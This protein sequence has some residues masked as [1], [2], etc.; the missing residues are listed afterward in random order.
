MHHFR[1]NPPSRAIK[2]RPA[3]TPAMRLL[4]EVEAHLDETG[5]SSSAFGRSVTGNTGLIQQLRAGGMVK[6]ATLARIRSALAG[7]VSHA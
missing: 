4:R 2:P 7:E 6:P 1:S 5:T 3:M